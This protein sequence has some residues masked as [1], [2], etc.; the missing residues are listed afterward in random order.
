[1]AEKRCAII[2][3]GAS[4]VQMTQAWGPAAGQLKVFQRTPNLA[5]PMRKRSLTVKEQEESKKLY[6]QFF[7]FREKTFGGFGYDWCE[8]NTFDDAPDRRKAF[9]DKLWTDGGFR[10][11]LASYKDSLFNPEANMESYSFWVNKTRARIA[12][13]AVRDLLAPLDMPHYFGIKRPSLEETY[14]E[15]FNRESVQLVDIEK[16]PIREFTETGILLEDATHHEFDVI[17]LATG[18]VSPP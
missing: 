7:E 2:G 10:F 3:T 8:R 13:P 12:N 18:F 11:W 5:L 4:G 1:M 17:A 15:Q 6:K 14:Y 9:Y 16:N